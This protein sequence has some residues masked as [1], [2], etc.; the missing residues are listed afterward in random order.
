MSRRGGRWEKSRI[1]IN[2]LQFPHRH[3]EPN[4][5]GNLILPVKMYQMTGTCPVCGASKDEFKKE[6]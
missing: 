2:A 6:E 3:C 4:G 1:N 5:R